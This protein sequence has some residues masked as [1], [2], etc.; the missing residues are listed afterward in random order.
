MQQLI[1][2]LRQ[3]VRDF[4]VSA[5]HATGY[6]AANMLSYN[7]KVLDGILDDLENVSDAREQMRLLTRAETAVGSCLIGG[8]KSRNSFRWAPASWRADV[9]ELRAEIKR[10]LHV[11][12]AHPGTLHS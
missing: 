1:P 5:N 3:L 4:H 9:E 6:T 7:A 2:Q 10:Q 12:A 8:S 11:L